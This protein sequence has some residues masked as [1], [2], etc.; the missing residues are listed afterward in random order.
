[1]IL[2]S[3]LVYGLCDLFQCEFKGKIRKRGG[4][5]CCVGKMKMF[6]MIVEQMILSYGKHSSFCCGHFL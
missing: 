3:C 5:E 1:M 6:S 4:Y 2:F